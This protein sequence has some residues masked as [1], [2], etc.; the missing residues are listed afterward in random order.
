MNS[1]IE[2]VITPFN[3]VFTLNEV[4]DLTLRIRNIGTVDTVGSIEILFSEIPNYSIS[5]DETQTVAP[6]RS[7]VTNNDLFTLSNVGNDLLISTS[8]VL[9]PNQIIFATFKIEALVSNVGGLV[10]AVV[11]QLSNEIDTTNNTAQLSISTL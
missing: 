10:N 5:F 3:N 7:R 1:N 9:T 8:T 4:K 11:S 2:I 6:T